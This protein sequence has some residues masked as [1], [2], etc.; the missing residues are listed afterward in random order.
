LTGLMKVD[1]FIAGAAL[2]V[3]FF[4]RYGC[5]VPAMLLENLK[6]GA[7]LKRS[8]ALTKG[9]TGRI[10]LVGLLMALVTWTVAAILQG[11]FFVALLLM[12]AKTHGQPPLWLTAGM[13]IAGGVGHALTGSLLMIGLVLLYYDIRGRK[14]GS[15]LQLLMA[16]LEAQSP[17]EGGPAQTLQPSVPLALERKSVLLVIL[18]TLVTFGLYYPYWFIRSRAG[19][20][21]SILPKK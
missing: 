21:A 4:L 15:H 3:W 18:L 5:S 16:T 19:S 10:F 20:I 6:A 13:N 8:V 17:V 12:A 9:N 2:A 11:P 14:E 1:L 7:A